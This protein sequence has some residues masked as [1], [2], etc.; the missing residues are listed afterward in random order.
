MSFCFVTSDTKPK[1]KLPFRSQARELGLASMLLCVVMVFLLC[2]F[3]AMIVNILEVFPLRCHLR[4]FVDNFI[5]FEIFP[6]CVGGELLARAESDAN[7]HYPLSPTPNY[8]SCSFL[9]PTELR[10]CKHAIESNQS[11]GDMIT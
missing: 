11:V 10:S 4:V 3:P 8:F 5:L 2:N 7:T 9:L 1:M 6:E